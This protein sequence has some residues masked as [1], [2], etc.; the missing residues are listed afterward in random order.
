LVSVYCKEGLVGLC[1][2]ERKGGNNR[3]MTDAEEKTFLAGFE[4]AAK[5]GELTMRN[6]SLFYRI[7]IPNA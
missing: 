1:K 6:F 3:N 4:E 5:R 7:V 2:D